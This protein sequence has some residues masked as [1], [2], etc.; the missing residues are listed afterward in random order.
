M[1]SR[2]KQLVLDLGH[3]TSFAEEDFIVSDANR[4]AFDH[5]MAFPQWA[6]SLSLMTGPAKSGKSH[7]AHIWARRSAAEFITGANLGD[8][9]DHDLTRPLV[10]DDIDRVGLDEH[11]LF[12]LL[13]QS[14]RDHRPL[15]MVARSPIG[16][17][18]FATDDVKSRA[19]LAAHF[20]VEAADDTQLSQMFAK[21][22]ADRQLRVD[23]KTISYLVARM[24]RSHEEVVA[25]TDLIDRL[26]LTRGRAIGRSI[27]AEALAQRDQ[28]HG[29]FPGA[30][31]TGN[32]N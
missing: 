8:V 24:E 26:A 31:E 22:L 9:T 25:L 14:M 15:L 3:T 18:P 11:L 20:A 10:I 1:R 30:D 6:S 2:A 23:P 28:H 27:A 21:L 32:E 19:R 17:W 29:L 4:L 5:V 16:E 7:L 12:H 13:N